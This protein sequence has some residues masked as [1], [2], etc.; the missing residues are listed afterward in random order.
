MFLKCSGNNLLL[1][2]AN[3]AIIANQFQQL[4]IFFGVIII[5]NYILLQQNDF[6]QFHV[7]CG[8]WQDK[9]GHYLFLYCTSDHGMHLLSVITVGSGVYHHWLV[10]V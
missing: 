10:P 6:S 4:Y 3:V 2:F 5:V 8:I 7:N 9:V 1:V